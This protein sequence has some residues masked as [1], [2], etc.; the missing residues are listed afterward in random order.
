MLHEAVIAS[1]RSRLPFA[2]P[3][4]D[5]FDLLAQAIIHDFPGRIALVSSFGAE[6]IVLLDMVARINKATPVLFN[7][8]GM[9]FAETLAYQQTVAAELGLTNVRI[10][11]PT[12]AELGRLDPRG[13]LHEDDHDACCDLRKVR[14]LKRALQPFAAWITGRK[15][16]QSASRASLPLVERDDERRVKLNPLADCSSAHI[17]NYIAEHDLPRHPLIAKGYPSIGC[18]PCT[19]SVA[20]GEAP[21]AGRWRGAS[22]EECGIHFVNGRAVRGA[23]GEA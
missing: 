16:F 1:R 12:L 7:Q 18:A 14:P 11:R 8:T 20:A 15:R 9:L 4:S 6:S 5:A 10:V 19:T 13:T 2:G 17:R 22:K 21:R 3:V 23:A